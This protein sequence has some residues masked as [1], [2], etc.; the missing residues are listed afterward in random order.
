MLQA[1][2]R[3]LGAEAFALPGTT[4]WAWRIATVVWV[5]AV[6]ILPL[7]LAVRFTAES[8]WWWERGFDQYD[9][10]RRTGLPR[11]E[12]DRGAAA[13][14]AYFHFDEAFATIT[15]TN[16]Q[17]QAEPLF[18]ERELFH[19]RD[20]KRLLS[21]TYDAGWAALG[22]LVAYVLATISWRRGAVRRAIGWAALQAGVTIGALM[23]ALGVI[24]L[25]GFDAAF[26]QFHLLFFTNDLWQLGSADRLIQLF[27]QDFFLETTLLIGG[28]VIGTAVAL[29]ALG[30]VLLRPAGGT[31]RR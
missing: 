15:V 29:A 23:V 14:R 4:R 24:A 2:R 5:I 17:G 9:A 10:E 8:G 6:L 16:A 30:W 26:R 7:S 25:T 21:R 1:L 3:S 19:L 28:V 22:F 12:V 13:L 18:S 27:P 11:A 20:V 31:A